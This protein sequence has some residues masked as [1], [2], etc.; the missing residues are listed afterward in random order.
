MSSTIENLTPEERRKEYKKNY[1]RKY[2]TKRK[3]AENG[4]EFLEKRRENS[5][6]HYK[7]Q[8]KTIDCPS[9]KLRHHPENPNCLVLIEA[10][11]QRITNCI[12]DTLKN[13]YPPPNSPE[14]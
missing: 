7:Y 6:K 4:S 9:C 2:Y 3:E 1:Q 8:R 10:R 11:K 13:E 12:L 14:C 5:R